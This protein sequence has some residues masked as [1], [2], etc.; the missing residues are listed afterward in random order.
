METIDDAWWTIR[1]LVTMD[2]VDVNLKYQSDESLLHRA[3]GKRCGL[4][5]VRLLL[6]N[7]A[8]IN[9][10]DSF[11]ENA[12]HHASRLGM[13]PTVQL[14]VERGIDIHARN[15]SNWNALHMA[16]RSSFPSIDI[17]RS[18]IAAG[19][20]PN[21]RDDNGKTPLDLAIAKRERTFD[22]E[23]KKVYEA[24]I[25]ELQSYAM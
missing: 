11:G 1:K 22:E 19:V 25:D 9:I 14:L 8:D 21:A 23:E 24:I 15:G 4:E 3:A 20:D 7:G 17:V 16:A 12:L 5:I 18:L 6:N 10:L 2:G 13:V